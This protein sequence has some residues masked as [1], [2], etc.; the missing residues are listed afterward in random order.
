MPIKRRE[1][2]ES[3]FLLIFEKMFRQDEELDDIFMSA[4]EVN[5]IIV[6]DEVKKLVENVCG[7]Q[8]DTKPPERLGIISKFSNKRTVERIPK[9]NLAIL[10]LAIYEAIYEENVPVNVAISEAVALAGKYALEPD[11]SFVNGVLGSFAKEQEE[12]Q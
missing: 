10:R 3:A 12:K 7:K 6:N 2:R 5:E 1:I 11:V 9:I 8:D 4:M